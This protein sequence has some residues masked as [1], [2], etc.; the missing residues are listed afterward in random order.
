MR[1][2]ILVA[3]AASALT[4]CGPDPDVTACADAARAFAAFQQALQAQDEAACRE[5]LT[6]ESGAALAEI[7]WAQVAAQRPLEI[8][9]A[10]RDRFRFFVR[11]ADPN[12]DGRRGEYVVVREHGRLVVDLVASAGRSARA[13]EADAPAERF[14]PRELTPADYDRIRRFELAQPPR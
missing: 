11:V 8:L 4:G 2:R 12:D 13:V 10:E 9:G 6:I 14:E 7:P 1:A 3:I 5:L